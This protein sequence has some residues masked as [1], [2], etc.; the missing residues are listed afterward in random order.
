MTKATNLIQARLADTFRTVLVLPDG[1]VCDHL[2]IQALIGTSR[3]CPNG[4]EGG[5]L[6]T[7]S[8]QTSLVWSLQSTAF[9]S[10]DER[11]GHTVQA[12]KLTSTRDVRTTNL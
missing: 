5:A 11:M 1:G 8:Q 3:R 9:N 12:A 6:H 7:Q 2:Q 4:C 10:H